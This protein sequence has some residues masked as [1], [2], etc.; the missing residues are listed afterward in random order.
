MHGPSCTFWANLTRFSL[1]P[2]DIFTPPPFEGTGGDYEQVDGT[3][4]DHTYLIEG[5][6]Y[7]PRGVPRSDGWIMDGPATV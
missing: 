1:K 5:A 7:S 3:R 2:P 6:R 4:V